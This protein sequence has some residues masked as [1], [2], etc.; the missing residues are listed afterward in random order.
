[1]VRIETG[2]SLIACR[3]KNTP[4]SFPP[5]CHGSCG[6]KTWVLSIQNF[7]VD[8]SRSFTPWRSWKNVATCWLRN[9]TSA[10]IL[11]VPNRM[12]ALVTWW[13]LVFF[14]A[15]NTSLTAVLFVC[16]CEALIL[17]PLSGCGLYGSGQFSNLAE[18]F[19]AKSIQSNHWFLYKWEKVIHIQV[20]HSNAWSMSI[21][22]LSVRFGRSIKM[23]FRH[24]NSTYLCD[25]SWW[26]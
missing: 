21:T 22:F 13:N 14:A 3:W 11:L 6:L 10:V 4:T 18:L 16:F 23:L 20:E 9:S 26:E 15:L 24:D 19:R 8:R 1:M 5:W 17:S 12:P 7:H 25:P 2:T